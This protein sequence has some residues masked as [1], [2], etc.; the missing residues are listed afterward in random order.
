MTNRTRAVRKRQDRG[1]RAIDIHVGARVRS[2]RIELGVSQEWL[3]AQLGVTFQQLQKY[4]GASNRV[5]AS[6]LFR[7]GQALDV[8]VS[9]FFEG[10][11]SEEGGASAKKLTPPPG[12]SVEFD[13]LQRRDAIELIEAYSA[14]ADTHMRRQLLALARSLAGQGHPPGRRSATRAREVRDSR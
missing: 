5:S 6:R 4:E 10:M 8:P 3:A 2:R 14:I 1:P 11:R 13:P 7:I 12:P 9:F